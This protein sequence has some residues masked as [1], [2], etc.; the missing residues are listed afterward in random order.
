MWF[1]A[2]LRESRDGAGQC[3]SS[4]QVLNKACFKCGSKIRDVVSHSP[5]GADTL[6]LTTV[7]ESQGEKYHGFHFENHYIGLEQSDKLLCRAICCLLPTWSLSL[8]ASTLPNSNS[9]FS[10]LVLCHYLTLNALSKRYLHPNLP[11]L[12]LFSK[13]LG[14]FYSI[15]NLRQAWATVELSEN[16]YC[17]L[18]YNTLPVVWRKEEAL[19]IYYLGLDDISFIHNFSLSEQHCQGLFCFLNM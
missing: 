19:T 1:T 9:V 8:S 3:P 13:Y 6:L 18:S 4:W 15:A 16:T 12:L 7:L 5:S 2:I 17:P 11:L 14:T 10:F